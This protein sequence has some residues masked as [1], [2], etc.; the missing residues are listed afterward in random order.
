VSATLIR[1]A[2]DAVEAI[3]NASGFLRFAAVAQLSA[4]AANATT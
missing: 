1:I 2:S 3:A 4:G